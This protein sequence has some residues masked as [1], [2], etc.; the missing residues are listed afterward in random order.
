[1]WGWCYFWP[2]K[3]AE[4][5]V[6]GKTVEK[7]FSGFQGWVGTQLFIDITDRYIHHTF[8]SS[9]KRPLIS[10]LFSFLFFVMLCGPPL[11]LTLPTCTTLRVE[12]LFVFSPLFKL[13]CLYST[14]CYPTFLYRVFL[15]VR[16]DLMDQAQPISSERRGV[17]MRDNPPERA[18]SK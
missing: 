14:A 18:S 5:R 16:D 3:R 8:D 4:E 17:P 6:W 2:C 12:L 10:S 1:M 13:F 11:L 7:G 9:Y 15:L